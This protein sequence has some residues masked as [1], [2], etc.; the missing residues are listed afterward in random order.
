MMPY[1]QQMY[2]APPPKKGMSGCVIA[3][4]IVGSLG[5]VGA[6]IAGV[7][8]YAIATSD[9]GKTAFKVIG[10]TTKIAEKGMKAPGTP[11]IRALG[12]EQAMVIDMKDFAVLMNDILDA[13][14]DASAAD[15]LMV[16]CQ[17]RSGG[18]PPSCDDVASTYVGAVGVASSQFMVSVTRQGN[19]NPLCQ[20][21]YDS[22]G[23]LIGTGTGTT[24]TPHHRGI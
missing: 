11:E 17:V 10:E 16:T 24:P 4:L 3:L 5:L 9:A 22:T 14:A 21:T 19:S 12:C 15:G 23:S 18:K 2:P 7:G 13:G 20:A 6:I 1:P 8:I